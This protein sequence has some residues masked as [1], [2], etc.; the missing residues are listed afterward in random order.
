M[1]TPG[2]GDRRSLAARFVSSVEDTIRRRDMLKGGERVLVAVSGGPDS[3]AL[4]HA[5]HALA[6][7]WRL[8]LHVAHYDH[9]LREGSGAD[10]SFVTDAARRLGLPCTVGS[11]DPEPRPRGLSPEEAARERRLRFLED[12]SETQ[13]CTRIATGHTLD[14]QAETVLMRL[15][16]GAGR[17][18]LAGIPPVRE[19]YIRPLIDR[20]RSDVEAY[21][22]A[23]GLRPVRDPTNQSL[24]FPRNVVRGDLMPIVRARLN[25]N[26]AEAIGRASDLL[27]DED[28]FLDTV[29][30]DAVVVSHEAGHVALDVA[31][32]RSLH[33][34]VQRRVVRLALGGTPIAAAHVDRVL[35][36]SVSGR[37][38]D[39]IDLPQ[40]LNA[41]LEYGSLLL[42]GRLPP[43]PP[44]QPVPLVIPGRTQVGSWGV[45]TANVLERRPDSWPDGKERCV[46]DLD[47]LAEPI[48]VR[49]RHRGDRFHPLG[50]T[51]TRSV[52]DVLADAKTPRAMRDRVPIVTAGDAVVWIVGHGISED[53]KGTERTRR[54]LW[55]AAEGGAE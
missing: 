40:G 4:L 32:L 3:L 54:Y 11:A 52:A 24:A 33:V 19:P 5:L 35:A 38:G 9:R 29:A 26:A 30:Q 46:V 23:L 47:R 51:G 13:R 50:M 53:A 18:G 28:A 10:A 45:V 39:A 22:T 20:E 41:R 44:I 15:I 2:A 17:R 36:L 16:S 48:V 27:R 6:P 7:A 14:D 55:L 34:A 1:T 31:A 25:A 12:V 42:G 21:C 37:S 49:S 8:D 43:V